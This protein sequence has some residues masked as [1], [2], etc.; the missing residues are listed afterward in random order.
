MV[1]RESV[2]PTNAHRRAKSELKKE[3]FAYVCE[4]SNNF[5]CMAFPMNRLS[6]TLIFI[7]AILST[8]VSYLM[9]DPPEVLKIAVTRNGKVTANVKP[10]TTEALDSI[11]HDLAGHKGEVWYYRQAPKEEPHPIALKIASSVTT[12]LSA[13]PASR[14]TPTLLMKGTSQFNPASFRRL[15][16][17]SPHRL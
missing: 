16:G 14:I 13:F 7:A 11:C 12:S 2:E 15:D 1:G 3:M 5:R 6:A 10:T 9:S 8:P 4:H 17:V